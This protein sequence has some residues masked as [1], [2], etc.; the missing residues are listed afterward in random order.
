MASPQIV[1]SSASNLHA[2]IQ[3]KQFVRNKMDIGASNKFEDN[4]SGLTL[5][6]WCVAKTREE[7]LKDLKGQASYVKSA[8][9]DPMKVTVETFAKHA[10]DMGCGNCGE[11]SALAFVHLHFD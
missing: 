9:L 5:P 8:G 7:I 3:T 6:V 2:A 10:R 4:L 11:Q 1:T